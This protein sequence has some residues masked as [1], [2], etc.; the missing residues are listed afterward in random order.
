MP[1]TI[2]DQTLYV[3][4][5]DPDTWSSSTLQRPG[6]LGKRHD[7]SD[8]TYQRVQLDSGCTSDNSVGVVA[9]NQL[10]YWKNKQLYLVTNDLKQAEGAASSAQAQ[11]AAGIFRSAVTAGYYCDN[12]NTCQNGC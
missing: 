12:S 8:R 7:D 2:N 9:A 3:P 1:N 6:E 5:G 10:A 4:T 11:F